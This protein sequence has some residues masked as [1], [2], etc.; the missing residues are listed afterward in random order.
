MIVPEGKTI[1]IGN[2]KYEPG[3]PIPESAK[4][5]VKEKWFQPKKKPEQKQPE[6]NLFE[7]KKDETK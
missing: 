4:H 7:N 1:Y 5:L 2:R 6:K 3:D